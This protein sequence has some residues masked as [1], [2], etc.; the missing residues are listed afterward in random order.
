MVVYGA[1][2]TSYALD[3][4]TPSLLHHSRRQHHLYRPQT[5]PIERR[6]DEVATSGEAAAIDGS[7]GPCLEHVLMSIATQDGTTIYTAGG[8]SLSPTH[9][10][11]PEVDKDKCRYITTVEQPPTSWSFAATQRLECSRIARAFRI[12]RQRLRQELRGL[13]IKHAESL[14]GAVR[15]TFVTAAAGGG[16]TT[17]SRSTGSGSVARFAGKNDV[18]RERRR[19]RGQGKGRGRGAEVPPWPSAKVEAYDMGRF[20][21][22]YVHLSNLRHQARRQPA[23]DIRWALA[24]DEEEMG[25]IS[26]ISL[27]ASSLEGSGVNAK[28]VKQWREEH[29][30][31]VSRIGG[32]RHPRDLSVLPRCVTMVGSRIVG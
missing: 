28:T 12:T 21:E 5:S 22:A 23:G 32:Y 25:R 4:R 26:T 24:V 8:G 9:E 29:R 15:R 27:E 17:G 13:A 2:L 19:W 18:N 7:E 10:N 3:G 14:L 20:D 30:S 11:H 6:Q 1:T 31:R 16:Y